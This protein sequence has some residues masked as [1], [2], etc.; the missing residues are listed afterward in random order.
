MSGSNLYVLWIDARST[1]LARDRVCL[2]YT[3]EH[4]GFTEK[5]CLR[6]TK[7][8]IIPEIIAAPKCRPSALG[9]ELQHLEKDPS[10]P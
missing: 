10:Y 5:K 6:L 9:I 7:I 1:A 4:S 3:I 2:K 8:K